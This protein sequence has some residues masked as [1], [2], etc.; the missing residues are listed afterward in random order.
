MGSVIADL[1]V[2][3]HGGEALAGLV[4][5]AAVAAMPHRRTTAVPVAALCALL[6]VSVWA[7]G[8]WTTLGVAAVVLAVARPMAATPDPLGRWIHVAGL[9]SLGGVW[10]GV[11]DTDPAVILGAAVLVPAAVELLATRGTRADRVAYV[12]AVAVA[13]WLGSAGAVSLVAGLGCVGVLVWPVG[14]RRRPALAAHAVTVAVSSRVASHQ[15]WPR[16]LLVVVAVTL[17]L[18]VV[19]LGFSRGR[20][21]W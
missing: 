16:A 10:A 1:F 5:G 19:T 15:P 2:R 3:Y 9:L 6:P 18:G 20:A 21:A 4:V 14:A 11:P 12:S 17:A 13:A 7:R 8:E